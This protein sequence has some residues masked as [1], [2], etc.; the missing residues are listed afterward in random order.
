MEAT[1]ESG[2]LPLLSLLVF[3]G[4]VSMQVYRLLMPAK[5]LDWGNALAEGMFYSTVNLA[6]TLPVTLPL[7]YFKVYQ[8]YPFLYAIVGLVVLLICPIVWPWLLCKAFHS[9]R[10]MVGLQVPFPTAWDYFFD[11]RL[12]LFVLIHLNGG[13][14]I[15]GYYGGDSYATSHPNEG[16]LYLQAV[17]KVDH[18]GKFLSPIEGTKG[19]LIR[20]DQYMY[21]KTFDVPVQ[22]EDEYG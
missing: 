12:P 6:L 14:M 18:D 7:H 15:G 2:T 3:P 20:K 1:L 9:K 22:K 5:G 4:I 13:Q 8:S 10:L 21:L 11:K 17:Y 19:L 16:D